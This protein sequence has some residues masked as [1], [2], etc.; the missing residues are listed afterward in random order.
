LLEAVDAPLD[1]V[2]LLACLA[3]AGA[4]HGLTL[5]GLAGTRTP[6]HADIEAILRRIL[7]PR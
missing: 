5:R 6:A 3:A 2:A 1:G 4:R 7:S